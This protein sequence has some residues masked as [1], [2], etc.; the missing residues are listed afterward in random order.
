MGRTRSMLIT[1]R[2][3]FSERPPIGARKFPAAPGIV[4]SGGRE[5]GASGRT[6]DDEIDPPEPFERARNGGAK[7]HRL[8]H[9]GLQR[10]DGATRRSG[11]LLRGMGIALDTVRVSLGRPM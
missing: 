5:A 4:V 2:N 7:L 11:E 9:V 1:V 10:N 6:A 8:A 3:A